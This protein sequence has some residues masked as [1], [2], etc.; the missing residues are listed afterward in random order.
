MANAAPSVSTPGCVMVST[1]RISRAIGRA[2]SSGQVASSSCATSSASSLESK[3][4]PASDVS[5][6]KKG[7]IAISAESAI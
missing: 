7:N 3:K 1:L 6:M 4:K 2:T 5:T